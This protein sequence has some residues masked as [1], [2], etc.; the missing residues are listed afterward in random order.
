MRAV[1]ALGALLPS[2]ASTVPTIV[3]ETGPSATSSNQP[4]LLAKDSILGLPMP[5]LKLPELPNPPS[6]RRR[7]WLFCWVQ[8]SDPRDE[9]ELGASG[10]GKQ[11]GPGVPA[12]VKS[13]R[14]A[15]LGVNRTLRGPGSMMSDWRSVESVMSALRSGWSP[16]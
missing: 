11:V 7:L 13:A 15:F 8:R 5:D 10:G 3:A 1:E 6:T 12:L 4:S 9:I 16:A 2:M 14:R